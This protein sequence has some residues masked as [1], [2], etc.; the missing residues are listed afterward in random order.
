MP[1]SLRIVCGFFN[2]PQLFKGCETGPLAYSPYPR[3]LESLTIC[4]C[5]YKGSTFYS[6]TF[7]TLSVGPAGVELATSNAQPTEPPVHVR[8][9][10][11]SPTRVSYTLVIRKLLLQSAPALL[12]N[13][14]VS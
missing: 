14:S 6:V 11:Y 8:P 10:S 12:Y 2:V 7:K 3:R 1:F 4:R 9:F 5:N 13:H